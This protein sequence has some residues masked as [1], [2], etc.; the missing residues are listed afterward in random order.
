MDAPHP[1]NA[2]ML[3]QNI[4][5]S[6]AARSTLYRRWLWLI[7][8]AAFVLRLLGFWQVSQSH[9]GFMVGDGFFYHVLAKNILK[10]RY[11]ISPQN[12][13]EERSEI[14]LR[15]LQ[16]DGGI[17]FHTAAIDKP[18]NYWS[19]GYPAFLAMV[20][21][22]F[23]IKPWIASLL[24]CILGAL[25]CL[26]LWQIASG[27]IGSGWALFLAG[28][29]AVHPVAWHSAARLETETLSLALLLLLGYF[30]LRWRRADNSM[31][32]GHVAILGMLGG[33][34]FLTR[35]TLGFGRQA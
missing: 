18:T 24:G 4:I 28:I 15:V 21:W 25:S 7:L 31:A 19:P 34:L 29:W 26:L 9:E 27:M 2:T 23:G 5:P 1:L 20:Y 11:Q 33:I 17:L 12:T 14:H 22:A 32:W 13:P 10:G 6:P 35:S 30:S 8:L 16:K 3:F